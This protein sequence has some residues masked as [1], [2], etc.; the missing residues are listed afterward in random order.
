MKVLAVTP[1][2]GDQMRPEMLASME[3]LDL[4]GIDLTW[5]VI[6][7]QPWPAPDH[8]NVLHMYRKARERA[9]RGRYD[10]MWTVEHDM[11]LKPDA[12]QHLNATPGDV[13][14]GVYII[15]FGTEVL[16]VFRYIDNQNMGDSFSLDREGLEEALKHTVVRCSGTGWGCTWI[17]R[18][19]LKAIKFPEEWP[20]NPP[21]DIA[22][23]HMVLR[24]GLV[25]NA[26]FRVHCGHIKNGET[27]WPIQYDK[28]VEYS[29][30]TWLIDGQVIPQYR[31]KASIPEPAAQSTARPGAPGSGLKP[32]LPEPQRMV[33]NI[34]RI[35]ATQNVT[36]RVG[37]ESQRLKAGQQYDLPAQDAREIVR[38]GYAQEATFVVP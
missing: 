24:K 37:V 34:I 14:Y 27:L 21:F 26:N 11:V 28:P 17:R 9:L 35:V 19:A 3:A 15:R 16:S 31:V 12:A 6:D 8:R 18:E 13:V 29:P 1:T 2:Y 23:S 7:E 20:E 30:Y 33:S 4:E 38:G 25:L 36:V 32:A 10:V 22:F 5:M